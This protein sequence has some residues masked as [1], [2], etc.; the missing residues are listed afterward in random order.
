[1]CVAE[2]ARFSSKEPKPE[3]PAAFTFIASSTP[4]QD[5]S[6]PSFSSM[7]SKR[8]AVLKPPIFPSEEYKPQSPPNQEINTSCLDDV[9][10]KEVSK[11]EILAFVFENLVD[12]IAPQEEIEIVTRCAEPEPEP[13]TEFT[14]TA[15][16]TPNEAESHASSFTINSKCRAVLKPP[17]FPSEEYKP[18]SPHDQEINTSSLDDVPIKEVSK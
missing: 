15:S 13:L 7:S 14:F 4:N 16:S 3:P 12:L 17:I 6:H 18:Q 10:I 11:D 5:V 9:P 2:T 8:G 1:M